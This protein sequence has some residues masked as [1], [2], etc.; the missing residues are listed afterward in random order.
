MPEKER[1]LS[2]GLI[3]GKLVIAEGRHGV[4]G[5]D[6][7]SGRQAWQLPR[8]DGPVAMPAVAVVGSHHV[9]LFTQGTKATDSR[10]VAYDHL[11]TAQPTL[12]WQVQ[13]D[14]VTSSGVAVD[15]PT[16]FLGDRSGNVYA[17]KV[18]TAPVTGLRP[19]ADAFAWKPFTGPGTVDA[20]PAVADGKVFA[21]LRDSTTGD[22]TVLALEEDTGK[23]AWP[24]PFSPS[25]PP[26]YGSAPTVDGGRVFVGFADQTIRA[27]RERDGVSLWSDRLNSPFFP[28]SAPAAA[29]GNVFAL[30]TFPGAEAGLYRLDA[31]TGQRDWWFEFDSSTVVSSPVVVGPYLYVALDD[32]RVAALQQAP[33]VEVWE[34]GTGRGG[35]RPV[36][37]GGGILVVS[38]AGSRGGLLGFAHDPSGHL[39]H[40][41]SPTRLNLG[42]SLLNYVEAFAVVVIAALF[43]R[44][45]AGRLRRR[46]T[47]PAAS[48]EPA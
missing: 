25:A 46:R 14:D 3:D 11:D 41:V 17:V 16:A 21:V 44:F 27:L 6:L 48:E 12:L 31:A 37:V 8:V 7:S 47:A 5:V 22:V 39:V 13:L 28:L 2:G 36:A 1:V 24:Q 38:K 32:G 20:P 35:L 26:T 15:G 34:R 9:L 19:T 45:G 33:D 43:L 42:R 4:Y 29:G 40:V 18:S 23:P 30:A 10:L